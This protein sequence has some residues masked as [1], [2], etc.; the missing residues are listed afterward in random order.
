M[1]NCYNNGSYAQEI[2]NNVINDA[3]QYGEPVLSQQWYYLP[4]Q[5]C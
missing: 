4:C 1:N 3:G 2:M 5:G